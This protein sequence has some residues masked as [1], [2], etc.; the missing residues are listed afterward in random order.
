[1]KK[2]IVF[3]VL[4]TVLFFNAFSQVTIGSTDPSIDGALLDIRQKTPGSDN[5]TARKGVVLPRVVLESKKSLAPLVQGLD[6]TNP[7]VQKAYTGMAVF[8]L[9]DKDAT[10]TEGSLKHGLNIWDG[11][12]WIMIGGNS[13]LK[14]FYMPSFNLPL[15]HNRGTY[16]H[17][18]LYEEYIK[19]FTPNFLE[20]TSEGDP[21][22]TNN[23]LYISSAD[24]GANKFTLPGLYGRF[25]LYYVV[26]DHS[27]E[28]TVTGMDNAGNMDYVV[29]SS[30]A[31]EDAF[32]NI[33]LVV[34]K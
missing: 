3:T 21:L 24:E 1:M 28:I 25:D 6:A 23:P 17:V 2:K 27:D 12:E 34:K 18:N 5:V 4:L 11:T 32:I 31:S 14:Y 7:T 19:R 16:A 33:I 9:A 10:T 29:N 26:L 8:N 15:E 20:D 13:T 30:T 22:E